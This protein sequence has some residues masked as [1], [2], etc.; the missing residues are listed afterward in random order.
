VVF[1]ETGYDFAVSKTGY[2]NT[3]YLHG[4]KAIGAA[5]WAA[6]ADAHPFF[7]IGDNYTAGA[8]FQV[9]DLSITTPDNGQVPEPASL[10][11][12]GIGLAGLAALRRRKA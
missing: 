4:T 11:L 1:S 12:L 3:D 6:L 9:A 2:G 8:Y 5:T 10:A 7:Q